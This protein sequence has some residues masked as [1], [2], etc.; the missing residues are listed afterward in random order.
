MFEI[1]VFLQVVFRHSDK[2]HTEVFLMSAL[3]NFILLSF[4]FP[5]TVET[6]LCVHVVCSEREK[7]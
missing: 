7:L 3:L 4:Y 1:P 5:V 6:E 2:Q